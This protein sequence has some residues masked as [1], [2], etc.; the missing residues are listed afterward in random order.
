[1]RYEAAHDLDSTEA[2][3]RIDLFFFSEETK[4]LMVSSVN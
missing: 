2:V 3:Q 1:M 4:S